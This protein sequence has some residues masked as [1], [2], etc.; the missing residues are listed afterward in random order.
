MLET[1]ESFFEDFA[2]DVT[3]PSAAVVRGIFDSAYTVALQTGGSD[4]RLVLSSADATGLA[5]GQTV[6][7]AA[8]AWKIQTIEPDGTGVTTLTLIRA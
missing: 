7:I 2:V 6:T 1:I 5:Y 3:L 4:P 8:V